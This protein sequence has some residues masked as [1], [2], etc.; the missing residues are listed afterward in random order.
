M[1]TQ[2]IV[3]KIP[4]NSLIP[5]NF[6]KRKETKGNKEEEI[7]SLVVQRSAEGFWHIRCIVFSRCGTYVMYFS[8]GRRSSSSSSRRSFGLRDNRIGY[9]YRLDRWRQRYKPTNLYIYI[10]MCVYTPTR[11]WIVLLLCVKE[12]V[13]SMPF[14]DIHA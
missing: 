6:N 13:E 4:Y 14:M 12:E 10:Y 3:P 7:L 1:H 2:K 5:I 11:G 9:G 8:S